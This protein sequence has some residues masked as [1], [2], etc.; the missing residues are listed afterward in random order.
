MD[1]ARAHQMD[2]MRQYGTGGRRVKSLIDA[3]I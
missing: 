3:A 1:L 2:Q